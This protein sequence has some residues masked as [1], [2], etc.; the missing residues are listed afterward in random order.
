VFL[1]GPLGGQVGSLGQVAVPGPDGE[2]ITAAGHDKDRALGTNL[3]R[4]VLELLAS[5]GELVTDLPITYRTAKMNA[6][7]DNTGFQVAFLIDL[8]A[9]H[10]AVGY[11]PDVA[12]GPGNQP[13]LPFRASYLQIGPI[14]MVTIPGELHPELWVGGYDC[15]SWTF[16]YPCLD[17]AEPNQPDWESAPAAPY[18]RDLVLA[19]P[20]V[21]YPICLG[22]AHDYFGYIVP[23]YNYVLSENSPYLEEAEGEHYEETYS[24]GPEVERHVVHP[25]LDLVEWRPPT[26]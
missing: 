12:L 24:L 1:Q 25:I 3:A 18:L 22:L 8:L 17:E 15:E 23:E 10:E 20:G 21:E 14:G 9:P 2:P 6:R 13:W 5:D 19:N 4:F 11:D 16:G 7:M 26:E